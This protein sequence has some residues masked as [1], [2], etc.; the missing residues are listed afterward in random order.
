MVRSDFPSC[1]T[2]LVKYCWHWSSGFVYVRLIAAVIKAK[3]GATKTY[4]KFKQFC[5][6]VFHCIQECKTELLSNIWTWQRFCWLDQACKRKCALKALCSL[7]M[8]KACVCTLYSQEGPVPYLNQREQRV[9]W[10][11][12]ARSWT[13][14]RIKATVRGVVKLFWRK[15]I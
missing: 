12:R 1:F 15:E 7:K 8:T 4:L 14:K 10:R 6:G 3:E 5:N 11:G 2:R 13:S 9:L